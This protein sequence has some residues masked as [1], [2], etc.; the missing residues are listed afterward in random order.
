MVYQ[1]SLPF[2]PPRGPPA[3]ASGPASALPPPC[4]R[5]VWM[6]PPIED[7][8]LGPILRPIWMHPYRGSRPWTHPETHLDAPLSRIVP[9]DPS[10]NL[11]GLPRI[12][13]L[14]PS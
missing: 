10:W 3:A 4:V 13:P 2:E 14:D 5:P 8:A 6:C 1:K 7:R 11:F 12:V 9:L